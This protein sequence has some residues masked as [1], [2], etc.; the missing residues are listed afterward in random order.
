[1]YERRKKE[2][3]KEWIAW[4]S[5]SGLVRNWVGHGLGVGLLDVIGNLLGERV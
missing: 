5:V 1:M 2:I 3:G 4:R